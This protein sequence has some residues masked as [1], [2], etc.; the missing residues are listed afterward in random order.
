MIYKALHRKLKIEQH[1][2]TNNRGSTKL[3]WKGKQF[4]LHMLH[5]SCYSCYKPEDKSWIMIGPDYD[6]V[7]GSIS[8]LICD[9]YIPSFGQ[10][11]VVTVK[12]DDSNLPT[13]NPCSV[14]S[15]L[16]SIKEIIIGITSSGISDQLWYM[17][18]ICRCCWNVATYKWKSHW[19]LFQKR[20]TR[21]KFDIYVFITAATWNRNARLIPFYWTSYFTR[22]Y[23]FLL[24]LLHETG[25]SDLYIQY[26]CTVKAYW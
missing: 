1:E 7:K 3:L 6:Y 15:L 20:V 17:Y 12:L 25:M 10:V 14:A 13:R 8:V 23:T 22:D 21:T 18:S 9:T 19:R 26:L 24:Q 5:L 2:P 4:L 16:A 11:M